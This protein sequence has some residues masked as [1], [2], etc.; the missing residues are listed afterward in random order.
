MR[1]PRGAIVVLSAVLLCAVFMP[2]ARASDWDKKTVVNFDSAV[3]IPGQVLP[4]GTYVFKLAVSDANRHIVQVWNEDESQL[5]ATVQ[6]IATTRAN[7]PSKSIFELNE[8][9][10]DSPLTLRAWFYPGDT[11]GQGFSYPDYSYGR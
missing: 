10:G 5:I 3:Q 2:G 7:P 1:T 9:Y 4:P 6:T 8:E 11:T